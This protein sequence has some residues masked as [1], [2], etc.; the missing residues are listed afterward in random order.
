MMT[1][2]GKEIGGGGGSLVVLFGTLPP[3]SLRES[4]RSS[5]SGEHA[6]TTDQFNWSKVSLEWLSGHRSILWLPPSPCLGQLSLPTCSCTPGPL[7]F[8]YAKSFHVWASAFPPG[9][10]SASLR[11]QYFYDLPL[12]S[13]RG[14]F[15]CYLLRRPTEALP[16]A[17]L[18]NSI[19]SPCFIFFDVTHWYL[20]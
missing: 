3:K 19:L 10:G 14:Q 16:K 15:K 7:S 12:S 8:K 11:S 18:L 1:R 2:L 20:L 17:A 6:R 9:L 5:S 13:F 4:A